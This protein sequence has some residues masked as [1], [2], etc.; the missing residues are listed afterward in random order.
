MG[1]CRIN[2][3]DNGGFLCTLCPK[4]H[5]IK[6]DTTI[7]KEL[8]NKYIL[9]SINMY[10]MNVLWMYESTNVRNRFLPA[11]TTPEYGTI[12]CP[13]RELQNLKYTEKDLV[14]KQ[15]RNC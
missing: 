8:V 9:Y 10:R 13:S 7:Y 5:T 6:V 15:F 12:K 1:F 4:M 14:E 11:I 2:V 3:L